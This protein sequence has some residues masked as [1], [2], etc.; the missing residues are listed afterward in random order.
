MNENKLKMNVAKTEFMLSESSRNLSK[1]DKHHEIDVVGEAVKPSDTLQYLGSFLDPVLSLK[2]FIKWKC[3]IAKWNL[4]K[5]KCIRNYLTVDVAK[6]IVDA[7]VTSH[8]DYVN[9]LLIGIRN[10]ELKKLH[11]TQNK[12]AKIVFKKKK[13]DST[14]D[15]LRVTLVT[16][17]SKSGIQSSIDGI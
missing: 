17:K 4:L 3:T 16:Y 5:I 7:L 6:T 14:S 13:F 1:I 11:R 12:A 8:L 15:C 9:G 2:E 10:T